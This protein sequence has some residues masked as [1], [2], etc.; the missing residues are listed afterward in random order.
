[1]KIKQLHEYENGVAI[2]LAP[3]T[4]PD[5]VVNP[6]TQENLTDA[7]ERIEG[8]IP[9]KVSELENDKGYLTSHQDISGKLD[10][11]VA[12]TT[13]ATKNEV[14]TSLAEKV[15]KVN[16]KQLS[17]EDF[18]SAYKTKLEG[19]NN[20]D[21]TAVNNAIS[22]LQTQLNTLV[23]GDTSDAIDSFNEIVAFLEGVQDT[24]TLEG[25][26]AG[27]TAEIAKKVD[28]VSGKGLSTN[29]FTTA[30]KDKLDSI[31]VI[32]NTADKDK[33][34]K[35]ADSAG[36]VAWTGVSGKPSL[37]TVA[38]SGS[39]NDLS[40]KPTIPT[41]TNQLTNGAGFITGI[42]KSMV[43][44]ALGYT[45]PTTDTNTTYTAGNGL[46]LS[47]TTFNV[48]AGTG[49]MVD[50]DTV[51]TTPQ[52]YTISNAATAAT[53]G[54]YRI[55][56]SVVNITNCQGIFQIFGNGAR[57][58][59]HTVALISAGTS[60]GITDSSNISVLQCSHYASDALTKVRI[61]YHTTYSSNYAYLEVYNPSA[62]ALS[63]T[64]KMLGGIGWS[65][66]TPSTAGSVPSGYSNKEAAL[67]DGTIYSEKF[68][69]SG[70]S[71]TSLNASNISSGTIGAARLPAAT[72]STQGAM[73]A[74]MVTKLNGIAA[75]ANAYS[76]PAATSSVLGGVKVGSNIT[77]SSG[78]ISLTKA[79][80]TTALGYTPPTT[81]TTYSA[82]TTSA[83]GLMTAAMVTK[84]NGIAAGANAYSLPAATSSV[85]GGVKVGS[86]ITVSSGT[87]SLTKANVTTAL[88]YTPPTTDTTYSVATTSAN[89]LM[90]S[91]DKAKADRFESYTTATTVASLNVGYRSIYVT[92]G[93]NASLSA[94]AT[95][96]TYNGRSVTA[97]VYTAAARTITIPTTGNYVSMCGS[98]YTT[99]AGGWVEFNLTCINGIWHIAKLEQE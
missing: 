88:G 10:V 43:T 14:T 80:V 91:A 29:D 92:L 23:S 62:A 3:V 40:N 34:V 98:S 57:A 19:L 61:V 79:N 78:T 16:G 18:T 59:K 25:I 75:G 87:I 5:A 9:S 96:A 12:A 58:G 22:S 70:A 42:N 72:T 13:Y 64:V 21:D 77:V 69:G 32:N 4:I 8:S 26:I 99:K 30:L 1:M 83:D 27:L 84:L 33:N 31:T 65:L 2:D 76:L 17:T 60:Y 94:S 38:T 44:T 90:S 39:Y 36:S 53:A 93:A 67:T 35:Y 7:L 51:C 24:G 55:A 63:I 47:S 71:L 52:L 50:A 11:S 41:N 74:A 15:D 97:Y 73:T 56:T 66:V 6:D 37:A 95:G 49:I 82:A 20:Y 48:G 81:N 28:K 86:N 85:L 89:G 46:T 54:W 68:S 45:P